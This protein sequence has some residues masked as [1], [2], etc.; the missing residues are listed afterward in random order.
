MPDSNNDKVLA[1]EVRKAAEELNNVVERARKEG[2]IVK[3]YNRNVEDF[4][5]TEFRIYRTY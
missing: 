4:D 3:Y 5:I 2:L 1:S